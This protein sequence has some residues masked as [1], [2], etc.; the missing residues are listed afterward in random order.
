MRKKI[1]FLLSV[2]VLVVAASILFVP[3][4]S[5][6]IVI[7]NVTVTVGN[8]TACITGCANNIWSSAAG[9]SVTPGGAISSL[10]LT[11]T[12]GFN[13]DTSDANAQGFCN[14]GCTTTLNINGAA[15]PLS[16][17]QATVLANNNG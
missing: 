7:N 5:H 11:Q 3:S 2:A 9:T 13:F 10:V 17:G 8:L 16:G 15:I 4:T 6:A 14:G 1:L 12:A